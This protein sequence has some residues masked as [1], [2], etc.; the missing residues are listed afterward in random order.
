MF[1]QHAVPGTSAT[2]YG[3]AFYAEQAGISRASAEV[4]VPHILSKLPAKSVL[5]VGCGIGTWLSVFAAHGVP[6]ILG[7]DGDY[8]ARDALLVRPEA[9]R[10]A[11]LTGQ[12]APGRRFDLAVSL[13]VAE[14]LPEASAAGF[15][16]QLC[17]TADA[18]LFSAALPTQG[19]TAHLNEQWPSY[20]IALFSQHGFR[21]LDA[22]RP[23]FWNDERID[24]CYR[25]NALLFINESAL[26]RFPALAIARPAHGEFVTDVVHPQRY[27]MVHAAA[28]PSRL[29]FAQLLSLMPAA[30]G[31]A[32][33][34]RIGGGPRAS[35]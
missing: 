25:N 32:L 4:V 16:A 22:L 3:P 29:S 10:P 24:L 31:R 23:R 14:H 35:A 1:V 17:Q 18:I 34:R 5:D 15:V 8:V 11:D 2:P 13:E 27:L 19:G 30:F 9:F 20:W 33:R 26:T 21:A 12:W 28:D 7:L 6:D